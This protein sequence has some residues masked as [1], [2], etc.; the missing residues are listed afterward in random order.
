MADDRYRFT[1]ER[2]GRPI[3]CWITSEALAQI[4][5][6][7]SPLSQAE[8]ESVYDKHYQAID[9]IVEMMVREIDGKQDQ[10]TIEAADIKRLSRRK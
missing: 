2:Y 10:I 6:V 3:E 7:R 1:G 8:M 9:R 5:G 4:A